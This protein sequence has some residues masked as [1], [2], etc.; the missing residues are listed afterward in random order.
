MQAVASELTKDEFFI[1]EAAWADCGVTVSRGRRACWLKIYKGRIIDVEP[2]RGT[3]GYVVELVASEAGWDRL[4][5]LDRSRLEVGLQQRT[6]NISGN[7]LEIARLW[8][9]LAA[10]VDA[11]CTQLSGRGQSR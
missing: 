10:L 3:F 1:R 6:L 4:A 7:Q 9:A 8:G 2:G 11:L 5:M